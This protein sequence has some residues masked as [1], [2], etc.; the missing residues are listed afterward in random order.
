MREEQRSADLLNRYSDVP[1]GLPS[2]LLRDFDL[3][4]I[5]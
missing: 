1:E 4:R 5:G 3:H 2:M